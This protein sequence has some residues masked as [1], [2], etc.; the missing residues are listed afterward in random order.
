MKTI[1]TFAAARSSLDALAAER[2]RKIKLAAEFNPDLRRTRLIEAAK[3]ARPMQRVEIKPT[4]VRR[5]AA[6]LKA[7]DN[8]RQR[9]IP[10]SRVFKVK[11]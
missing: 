5:M 11:K 3:K 4:K 6:I 10:L 2:A 8:A 7:I 9:G 1:R